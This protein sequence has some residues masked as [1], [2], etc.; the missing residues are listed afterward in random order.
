M[1]TVRLR[2]TD[3]VPEVC[4]K[5]GAPAT[6]VKPHTFSWHPQWATILLAGSLCAGGV[7]VIFIALIIAMTITKRRRME[8]PFCD[9]HQHYWLIRS[10][11]VFGGLATILL[12]SSAGAVIVWRSPQPDWPLFGCTMGAVFLVWL[13]TAAL[14]QAHS[15][16]ALEITDKSIR[17]GRVA[18]EFVQALKASRP[19]RTRQGGFIR[20]RYPSRR[21]QKDVQE[22]VD[23]RSADTEH[24][25]DVVELEADDA[26]EPP[27]RR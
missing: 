27:T 19:P 21:S 23:V 20:G 10:T 15:I 13:I 3:E 12:M 25:L 22:P 11:F 2:Q 16:Q 14:I 4:L 18:R 1:A 5:C 7:A 24:L 8:V 9:R 26:E 17:L 6:V